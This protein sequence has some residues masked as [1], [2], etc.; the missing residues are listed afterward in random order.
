MLSL[1]S[2]PLLSTLLYSSFPLAFTS[3]PYHHTPAPSPPTTDPSLLNPSYTIHIGRIDPNADSSNDALSEEEKSSAVHV[4][5]RSPAGSHDPDYDDWAYLSY[6]GEEVK[7]SDSASGPRTT[8]RPPSPGHTSK[9]PEGKSSGVRSRRR[10]QPSPGNPDSPDSEEN[11]PP[12][13][14]PVASGSTKL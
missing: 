10:R 14:G 1:R 2:L 5:P 3:S 12:P 9:S 11:P 4:S 6:P 13:E 7:P 8:H